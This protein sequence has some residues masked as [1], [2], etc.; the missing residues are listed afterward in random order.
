[1]AV[2]GVDDL[3]AAEVD[4]GRLGDLADRLLGSDENGAD[5]TE[6]ARLDGAG[7]GGL[8]TG[9]SYGSGHRLEAGA[10]FQK[11]FVFS[12]S[13]C[14]A[15]SAFA[16]RV[17]AAG[18]VSRRRNV[19][20]TIARATAYKRGLKVIWYWTRP[21]SA[22]T[23]ARCIEEP[24]MGPI[25]AVRVKFRKPITPVEVPANCGGLTSLTTV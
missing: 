23:V 14:H 9:V 19:V 2:G 21:A 4:G 1:M 16:A 8:L 24:K 10:A 20:R 22:P 5:Q 3:G 7:E 6:G 17:E 11:T 15:A 18:P 25:K 12:R 13:G